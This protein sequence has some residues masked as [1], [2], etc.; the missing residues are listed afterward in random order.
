[1]AGP[2]RD[3]R[4]D[5]RQQRG[6]RRAMFGTSACQRWVDAYPDD[7][8]SAS[9]GTI[10]ERGVTSETSHWACQF[11]DNAPIPPSECSEVFI[12]ADR[13]DRFGARRRS[14][15]R[16]ENDGGQLVGEAIE[17]V[18]GADCHGVAE[19]GGDARQPV[20][21]ESVAVSLDDGYEAIDGIGDTGDLRPPD[22]CSNRQ[23][24]RH[25]LNGNR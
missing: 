4:V 2:H 13:E 24:Y 9:E 18:D 23:P 6:D 19:F 3:G 15:R 25:V 5:R 21:T 20:P 17:F 7:V 8:E 11:D 1:M 10:N 14:E 22:R 12:G 16:R